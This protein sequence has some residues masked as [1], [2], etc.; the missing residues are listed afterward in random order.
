M[1]HKNEKLPVFGKP[2]FALLLL[3]AVVI[4]YGQFLWNPIVFDDVQF[5]LA[6]DDVLEHFMGFSPFEVRWLPMASIAWTAH[7]LGRDLIWFRLEGL[8]LHAATGVALFFFLERLFG[9]VL[10]E[11]TPPRQG[12]FPHIWAAFF[13]AL[14]FVWH[15]VAVYGAAYLVERTIVMATLFA[16]LALYVYMRG[17][18]EGRPRL[19]WLSVFFYYLAVFSKEH[20][21]MLPAVMLALTLLLTRPSIDLFKRLWGVYAACALIALFVTFQKLGLLGAVYEINAPI[22]L[23]KVEIQNAYPL[24]VLTQCYLFFKYWFLWLLPNPAWMS[25]DMREPF[26]ESI[27]SP[28]LLALVV[29]LAYGATGIKFLLKRGEWGLLGF[30]MLF[31][32]LLF[33]TEFSTVRI[34]ESFVLY[35]SY[36]WMIGIFAALP[37]VTVRFHI[38]RVFMGMLLLAVMLAGLSVN[39]LTT[40]AN[41]LLLWDDALALVKEKHE[42]PGVARIYFNHGKYLADIGH[43]QEALADYKV[44]AE[45][46]PTIYYYHYGAAT[47]YMNTAHYPE[48]I[49]EFN[50]VLKEEPGFSRAYYGRGVAELK[51]GNNSAALA[52][53]KTSCRMGWKSGCSRVQALLQ[54]T[55]V[56]P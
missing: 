38:S 13:G 33:A 19:L 14:I 53:L 11:D 39:R 37:L 40:F 3:I 4:I 43:H 21:V 5:F 10:K 35:R 31:P 23:E 1:S 41:P 52:D 46:S 18:S 15:P 12:Q 22:M 56:R 24:S 50:K 17:L 36:L 47:G 2:V 42:L 25:V 29:F 49:A 16:M 8:L 34:Q 7:A 48:A 32:W 44:A 20:V 55:S 28:Y 45:L 9:L 30:A 6:G 51:M 54:G 27:L 26:A